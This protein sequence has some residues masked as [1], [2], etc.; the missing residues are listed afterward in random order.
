MLVDVGRK[1]GSVEQDPRPVLLLGSHLSRQ[2]CGVTA[3][4]RARRA[5]WGRAAVRGPSASVGRQPGREVT[6]SLRLLV[7]FDKRALPFPAAAWRR[8]NGPRLRSKR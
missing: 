4:G 7:L 8:A 5:G 3:P 1:R 6:P 2:L